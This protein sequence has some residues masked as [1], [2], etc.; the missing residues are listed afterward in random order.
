MDRRN[1]KAVKYGWVAVA[2]LVVLVPIL[3]II[4]AYD[5]QLWPLNSLESRL[6]SKVGSAGEWHQY[7]W[8][9]EFKSDFVSVE[10]GWESRVFVQANII[11]LGRAYYIR[12]KVEKSGPS[13]RVKWERNSFTAYGNWPRYNRQFL[14]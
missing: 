12:V 14:H 6:T 13:I 5:S 3:S 11:D 4:I 8:P 1:K 9:S 10:G 2:C 7:D